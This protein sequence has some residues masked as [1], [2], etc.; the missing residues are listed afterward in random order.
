VTAA[1][2][3]ALTR[4][5]AGRYRLLEPIARGGMATIH[6]AHDER[7]RRD[8]AVK[9]IRPDLAEDPVFASRFAQEAL[10]AAAIAHPNAVTVLDSG[11]DGS[12]QFIVMEL[13]DGPD[14]AALLR[15][16]RRL[17]P[18]RAATI[19]E[20][21]ASA[22]AAAH[23]RG[24]VHRDVKPGNILLGSDGRALIGD[25]GIAR[26]AGDPTLTRTGVTLGSVDYFSPE[27]ARGEEATVASD[28]YAL[29][30]VLYEMLTGRRPF[31]GETAYQTAISRLTRE[32]PPLAALAPDVPDGLA[33]IVRRAMAREPRD[34]Y[35]TAAELRDS[36]AAWRA[37]DATQAAAAAAAV[38]APSPP[39]RV[40]DA[41]ATLPMPMATTAADRYPR[42]PL[43]RPVAAP[44]RRALPAW[45]L[46]ATVTIVALAVI[47][48][49]GA[50]LLDALTGGDESGGA[51]S[52]ATST[53]SLTSSPSPTPRSPTPSPTATPTPSPTAAPATPEPTPSPT[54]VTVAGPAA[55]AG[56]AD[57]VAHWYALVEAH[58]FDA[59]YEM[60]S[61][62]MRAQFDRQE[63]LD[64]RWD[65]TADITIH[66]LTTQEQSD[67]RAVVFVDFTETFSGGSTQRLAG[68]W[69]L[70]RVN[71]RWLLDQ[72]RF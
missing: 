49:A 16:E 6:R 39:T 58:D 1:G 29:G 72:P 44:R 71:G 22:L 24:I 64:R 17:Q 7:L 3:P 45:L 27:Q 26:A 43:D 51:L 33:A 20:E 25:F 63:N 57:T 31:H 66:A 21:V 18:R 53:P 8:V 42:A 30:V 59:A 62:R 11:R 36:L 55:A 48:F 68:T 61:D 13:V 69:E 23:A 40:A 41:V 50:T 32:P 4:T 12:T 70:V 67:D 47:G 14:L 46:P 10:R 60:W 19:A 2:G 38:A 54:P 34:R 65:D 52:V 28:I 35:A 5:I 56:P 9:I 37:T 15:R